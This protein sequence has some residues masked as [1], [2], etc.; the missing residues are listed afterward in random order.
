MRL[1]S[2]KEKT[3][4][5]RL[6][7][8][9]I[10]NA[11]ANLS[12]AWHKLLV[13]PAWTNQTHRQ[14]QGLQRRYLFPGTVPCTACRVPGQACSRCSHFCSSTVSQ[15]MPKEMQTK[16]VRWK[17]IRKSDSQQPLIDAVALPTVF[18]ARTSYR[19]ALAK[20]ALL[21]RWQ[22]G[23]QKK[24]VPDILCSPPVS[25]LFC[26]ILGRPCF[27]HSSSSLHMIIPC[28]GSVLRRLS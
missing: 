15:T 27:F 5:N 22:A 14:P 28:A 16:P 10:D 2:I 4:K 13:A 23:W 7:F 26:V 20:P 9:K 12:R 6:E 18:P 17:G 1:Q 3:I 19:P 11:I 21:I 8:V 25:I 24:N